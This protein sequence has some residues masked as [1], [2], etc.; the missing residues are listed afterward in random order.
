MLAKVA[1]IG[2][3][4][5]AIASLAACASSPTPPPEPNMGA[6]VPVNKTPPP[7]AQQTTGSAET[8]ATP[9]RGKVQGKDNGR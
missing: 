3:M 9:T 7:I 5:V 2:A 6:L 1:R 4:T 8:V